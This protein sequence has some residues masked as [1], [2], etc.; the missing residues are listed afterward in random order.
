MVFKYSI[1]GLAVGAALMAMPVLADDATDANI[2]RIKVT[3]RT[4]NDYKVGSASGAMR[5]DI[6]LMDTPQSVN[7]IPDFVTD[8]QLATNLA[9]VLVND[10]S[11]TAGTTRWN[12]QVFSIRGFEIDSGNGYLINGHQ[13]WSHYVQPI[14]TLQQVEVLKGP[15]SMLYGQSGPGGL[16]NMVTKKPTYD[17]ML[18]LGF[19]TDGYGSTRAQLDAGGS[20][21]DAQ[22]IRYRGVLVKQD[23]K[24]W[25]EYS[26]TEENQERD[27][28]L[29]YLNLEFDVSDDV[30][31]SVKYD[32]TQDKAGIDAGG[33]LD[34]QG[35]V[36]GGRK[37]VWDAPW[38]FTDN[39]ISNLGA[40]ITWQMTDDWKV[41][42]GYNDQ[43]FDRQRFDS[44][45]VYTA[46]PFTNG[47][48]ISPFDRYDDWQHKTAFVDF[49]GEF[50]LAGM[51]HQF[52]IGAN[53]LDY[54]YQQQIKRGTAQT[55]IPGQVVIKPELDYHQGNLSIPSE[56]K[57]YGFYLQD[58]MTLNEQWKLLAGVR[59][60]EQKKD[61]VGGNSYAVSP[62]FGVIYSPMSN[63]SIYVNYSKSFA[64][65]GSVTSSEDVNEGDNLK[66]EYG[67]Q[68]EL[69][70]KWELFNDSLLLTAAVF[71]ITV[72]NV[73]IELDSPI[74]SKKTMTTQ[75]GEQHH[76][77]FEIGAQ[78]QLGD[79]WFVTS[80]MM[81][82]DAEY[83]TGAGKIGGKS[84]DGK[85]PI[86][87][88]EWSANIWTRYEVTDNFAM[89]F[90]AIYVGERFADDVNTITKDGYVRFDIGAAYTMDIMGK[91]VS[92][93]AN[94]RNLFDTEYLDGGSDRMVTIGQDRNFSVAVEAKF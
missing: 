36:I 66:P 27:R 9:E 77:G 15:S 70:T 21:N 64:P 63:G 79:S 80:S 10:S 60:D 94:V 50:S 20:L 62:K 2:E 86:D 53:Y 33:W 67:T 74:P 44:A 34:A 83:N 39:T 88:P 35:N 55:V 13:Q 54:F 91:D 57:Y 26:T 68:Y 8:E 56:Y 42:V 22:S 90:G 25:R 45:P 12:R 71:D 23:T 46:D 40:D 49:T 37:T 38:A 32:H 85:T 24:Y 11:V 87:A 69:G 18:D 92:L 48:R 43:Q 5:G 1:V 78:G 14:E 65:K 3:G 19:D 61:G 41:K 93:R 82:L 17:S 59:Y 6:N 16:V 73:V 29:G 4:F 72:S 84:L 30:T 7:V 81:Y 76:R 51:E 75:G 47:Y 89:N 28:W 31:L 52:L 58:L